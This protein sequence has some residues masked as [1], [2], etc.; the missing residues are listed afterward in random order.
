MQNIPVDMAGYVHACH[1]CLFRSKKV[2]NPLRSCPG[3]YVP[4][5]ISYAW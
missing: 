5:N 4:T 2:T 1:V 3:G